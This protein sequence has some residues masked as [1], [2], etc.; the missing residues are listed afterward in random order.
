MIRALVT[1]HFSRLRLDFDEHHD[2]EST[3]LHWCLALRRA[4]RAHPFLTELIPST[5]AKPS[6][7]TSRNY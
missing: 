2:W 1:R 5:I 6:R 4:L 7:T 3:A